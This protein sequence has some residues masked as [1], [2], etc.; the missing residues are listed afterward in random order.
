[1]QRLPARVALTLL[2]CCAA[3]LSMSSRVPSG[4]D[5]LE[6]RSRHLE[7][8]VVVV[9]SL[10]REYRSRLTEVEEALSTRALP[11]ATSRRIP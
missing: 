5:G 11:A 7:R 9:E 6:D 3:I 10:V 8:G 4:V 2:L 1:M